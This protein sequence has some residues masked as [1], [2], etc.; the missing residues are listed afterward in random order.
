MLII[1]RDLGWVKRPVIPITTIGRWV[2]LT[3]TPSYE[4]MDLAKK[5][6]IGML[7]LKESIA[8]SDL[9]VYP[10]QHFQ[11]PLH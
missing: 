10:K 1:W 8:R 6:D 3:L 4:L 9:S 2:S 11:R 7:H 5:I